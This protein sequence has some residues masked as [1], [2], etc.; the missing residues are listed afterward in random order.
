MVYNL[1]KQKVILGLI[2]CIATGL[3]NITC[4]DHI[5]SG[6]SQLNES[7]RNAA[8]NNKLKE[9]KDL[10][11]K[12]ADVKSKN[13]SKMTALHYSSAYNHLEVSRVL[14][15]HGADVNAKNFKGNTPLHWP[16]K[17]GYIKMIRLLLRHGANPYFKNNAGKLPIDFATS[18]KVK[19]ILLKA[20]KKQRRKSLTVGEVGH[21]K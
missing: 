13:K 1:K 18:K 21:G 20:M 14:I 9:V 4:S 16:A 19:K 5:K 11:A 2:I 12:G 17:Q 10:L 8:S 6:N 7:L 15:Q 3:L